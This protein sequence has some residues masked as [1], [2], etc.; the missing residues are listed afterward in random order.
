MGSGR[1]HVF[2]SYNP[3]PGETQKKQVTLSAALGLPSIPH[4]LWIILLMC[5]WH[6]PFS[7]CPACFN[8]LS[9]FISK[10]LCMSK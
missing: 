8:E 6:I 4:T 3:R 1:S 10:Q 2:S 9:S 5:G 7:V